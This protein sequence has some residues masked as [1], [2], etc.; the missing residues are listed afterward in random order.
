MRAWRLTGV[1][2]ITA[3]ISACG[4][5][6]GGSSSSSHTPSTSNPP[7]ANVQPISVNL[8]PE[9]N[10]P[11]GLFTSV[12]VC[13]PGTTNCQ[14][15]NDILVD[16]G[17][18]GLRILSSALTLSL[19]VQTSS[20]GPIAECAPFVNSFTWGP[21]EMADIQLAS[22]RAN[23]VPVQIIGPSGF[24][25]PPTSCTNSGLPPHD[26]VSTLGANGILGIGLFVHDCGTACASIGPSNPGLYYSCSSTGCVQTSESLQDQVQNPVPLFPSD[27]NGV[28]IELP[29]VGVQGTATVSG[30]LIFGIGTQSN[31]GLDG[32]QVYT[33]NQL[34]N[35]TTLYGGKSYSSFI[36]SGSNGIYFLSSAVSGIPE[37]TGGNA[38]FYCP[39][40]NLNLTAQNVGQNGATGTVPFSIANAQHLFST[41]NAAFNDLGGP[42]PGAFDWGVP[43]F[44]G[45]KIFFA[46]NGQSTP[47]GPG[48]YWAY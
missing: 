9:G 3:L 15:I 29:A 35:F 37:C 38:Q 42:N 20:G 41:G 27:N 25:A 7:A 44:F 24:P 31:N 13:V 30:S 36:D 1:F 8:G 10:Y 34:A 23:N 6:G 5:G 11:N 14:T 33:A 17:S 46:I 21:V 47:A 2:L 28:L 45:R 26:T 18:F 16:T 22:E 40:S 12:I 19:P 43:F 39:S 4:G 32:A 48:P